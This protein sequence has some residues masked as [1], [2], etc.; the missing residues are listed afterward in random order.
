VVEVAAAKIW[1]VDF[2]TALLITMCNRTKSGAKRNSTH[3][4]KYLQAIKYL[5]TSTYQQIV[6]DALLDDLPCT[7]RV[8]DCAGCRSIPAARHRLQRGN[9]KTL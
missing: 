4:E 8:S 9:E 3:T 5:S 1:L 7:S 2:S 6:G